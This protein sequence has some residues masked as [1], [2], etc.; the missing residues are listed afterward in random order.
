MQ[1]GA[2]FNELT[3]REAGRGDRPVSS[4]AGDW[5]VFAGANQPIV[6]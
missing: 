3:G 1:K 6:L 5:E 2:G 4:A